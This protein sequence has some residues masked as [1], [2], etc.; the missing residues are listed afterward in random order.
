MHLPTPYDEPAEDADFDGWLCAE[1]ASWHAAW[2]ET[3]SWHDLAFIESG[4]A[5][6]AL[7]RMPTEHEL[8]L[9]DDHADD[10]PDRGE[11]AS[12]DC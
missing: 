7:E 4:V 6:G 5:L 1:E 12:D 9:L 8:L 3:L 11:L 2:D 10:T